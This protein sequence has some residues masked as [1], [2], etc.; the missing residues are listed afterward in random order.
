MDSDTTATKSHPHRRPPD[1]PFSA[2]SA[3]HAPALHSTPRLR[4]GWWRALLAPGFGVLLLV[5]WDVVAQSGLYADFIVPSPRAVADRWWDL[6]GDGSL[7]RHMAVTLREVLVG[8]LAGVNAAFWSGYLIAKSRLVAN[9]LMPYL[10]ALQAVPI[11][12]IAPL[13]IIWF[14]PGFTSK[15][16]ICALLVFFP[17]LVNTVLGVRNIPSELRDLME[18]LESTPLQT[19]WY[20][21]LPASM[22]I[23]IGG[24]KVSAT[25]SVIGAVVAEFVSASEGLGYLINFGRGTFDTPLVIAAVFTLTVVALA[26]YGLASWLERLLLAWQNAGRSVHN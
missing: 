15:V 18:A 7:T 4:A 26:L 20:L 17:M 24:L 10:V 16:L 12:A 5:L 1:T 19:F 2:D 14:G 21:E 13:L 8:L 3:E 22:P 25:L 23:V 6:A 11:V 9:I